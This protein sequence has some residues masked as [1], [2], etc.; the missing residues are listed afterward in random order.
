MGKIRVLVVEDE[1]LVAQDIQYMLE[2]LG[3]E[4]IAAVSS[5]EEALEKTAEALPDLILMDIVLK[6]GMDGITAAHK[7]WE[8]FKIPFIYVTAFADENTLARAKVT[9]PFGYLHKPFEERELQ[10]AIEIALYK[11][12]MEKGL[13]ES[14]EKCRLEA[15]KLSAMISAME[16]GVVFADAKDEIIEVNEYALKLFKKAK[17]EILGKSLWEFP[18]GESFESLRNLVE[19]F[20]RVSHSPLKVIQRKMGNLETVFRVQPIY[21]DS[22]YQGVLLNIIDVT[23]FVRAKEEA[24]AADRAKSEFLANMSHEIRTPLNA[25][26]GMASLLSSTDL[27]SEQKHYV[28]TIKESS[29][30]LLGII[31]DILDFSKIEAGKVELSTVEFDLRKLVESVGEI[32]KTSALKKKIDFSCS[33]D[34]GVPSLVRGDPLKIR[35]ILMNIG[36]NAVKFTKKG[37]VKIEVTLEKEEREKAWLH[38]SIRDTGIGIP[39]EKKDII[40]ESFRQADSSMTR[41][42]G[43]TGLGLAISKKLVEMMG[44]EIG[45]ISPLGK[46]PDGGSCFWFKI[47]LRKPE[48]L[49]SGEKTR[50]D[51]APSV[52]PSLSRAFSPVPKR[53]RVRLLLVED[54]LINQKVIV[55]ILHKAGYSVDVAE[56]G[57]EAVEILKKHPYDLVLMDIQMP[58]MDGYEATRVIRKTLPR[59]TSLPIIA[60]TAHALKGEREKCLKAGMDDYL[61]KPIHPEELIGKIEKWTV[62]KRKRENSLQIL[63]R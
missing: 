60:M 12:E 4:V 36:D 20:K 44:G 53:R 3:Y 35:Q 29:S 32:L 42:Y 48:K 50:K 47:P 59:K 18:S 14:E 40:F 55:A 11:A 38:F 62:L 15:T 45:F 57:K 24:L 56:N 37:R 31:N 23:E 10:S 13:R 54:N 46:P 26:I 25:T 21:K 41:K 39:P 30:L 28:E 2:G 49:S 5:G 22:L 8:D 34:P 19:K 7:I 17:N 51:K 1:H 27:D 9:R 43:G 63:E 61:S 52:S 6:G 33:I 16:E 58:L